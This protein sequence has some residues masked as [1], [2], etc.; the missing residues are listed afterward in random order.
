MWRRSDRE[1][2]LV[3]DAFRTHHNEASITISIVTKTPS[4]GLIKPVGYRS[5]TF[6]S[7]MCGP[8]FMLAPRVSLYVCV[9]SITPGR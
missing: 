3:W 6:V 7:T 2:S 4:P 5:V 8:I 9:Y 1:K